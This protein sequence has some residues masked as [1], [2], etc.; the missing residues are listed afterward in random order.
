MLTGISE[1]QDTT[2]LPVAL[3]EMLAKLPILTKGPG[4]P[5][6]VQLYRIVI[7][8]SEGTPPRLELVEAVSRADQQPNPQG[9][10]G[11]QA[12]PESRPRDRSAAG[13]STPEARG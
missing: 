11:A 3:L 4:G 9:I 8:E 5:P 12:A 10:G 1:K 2:A 13:G 6:S 7:D